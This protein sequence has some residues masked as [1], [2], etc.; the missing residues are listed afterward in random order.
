VTR[1]QAVFLDLGNVLVFHDNEL[2]LDRLVAL[3]DRDPEVVRAALKPIW[4]PCHRGTLHGEALRR[5]VLS[6]ANAPDL[7]EEAFFALWSCHFR[8]HDEVLPLVEA[9]TR[10][11]KVLLLSNTDERHLCSVRPGLPVLDRF[12]HLVVSY[13]LGVA[14][15][16]PAIFAEA[17]KR[18]GVPAGACA[19]FDDVPEYVEAAGALGIHG[20]VFTTA[21]RFRE[22]LAGL[23]LA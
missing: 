15:P 23:G 18:A 21:A 10:T 11:V 19:Y 12:H 5:A 4:E 14:K 16:D 20:R 13:E 3:G 7:D 1:I 22:Q 2:L 9:L 17:V 8:I 6:A